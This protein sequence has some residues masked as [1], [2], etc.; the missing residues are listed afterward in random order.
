MQRSG[1]GRAA[2]A[3]PVRLRPRRAP[4]VGDDEDLCDTAPDELEGAGEPR[5]AAAR[6]HDH[7]VG[8]PRHVAGR[9]HE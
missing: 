7:S 9:P 3:E 1:P 5:P 8:P 4:A 2:G 6:E